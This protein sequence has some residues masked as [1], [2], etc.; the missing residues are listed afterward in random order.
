MVSR[1]D[2][3]ALLCIG[4]AISLTQWRPGKMEDEVKM[5]VLRY[6]FARWFSVLVS[7]F[8]QSSFFG[9]AIPTLCFDFRSW[10]GTVLCCLSLW[11][12]CDH[13]SRVSVVWY[14]VSF[15]LLGQFTNRGGQGGGRGRGGG[16]GGG[17]G[18]GGKFRHQ[19]WRR[20]VSSF[21]ITLSN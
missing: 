13:V 12:L 15:F 7:E 3:L 21:C 11:Q 5:A 8:M 2:L 14:L 10:I 20:L 4:Q 9:L 17:G 18:R 6:Q 19:Q 1:K 16:G